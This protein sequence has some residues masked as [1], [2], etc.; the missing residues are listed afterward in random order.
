MLLLWLFDFEEDNEDRTPNTNLIYWRNNIDSANNAFILIMF[1]FN[2]SVTTT[3][4]IKYNVNYK[5]PGSLEH[6]LLKQWYI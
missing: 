2:R 6:C 3:C 5:Y 1:V 4:I